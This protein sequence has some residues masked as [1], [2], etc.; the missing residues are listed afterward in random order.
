MK[1]Y[2][3]ENIDIYIG[4]EKCARTMSSRA[5][6]REYDAVRRACDDVAALVADKAAEERSSGN[7]RERG[8]G[9]G[10]GR[11]ARAVATAKRKLAIVEE[12]IADLERGIGSSGV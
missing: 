12:N 2:K 9:S 1:R 6:Q 10:G 5:W 7:G 3:S 8:G 4:D 11:A